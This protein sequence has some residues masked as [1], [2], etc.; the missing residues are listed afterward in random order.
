MSTLRKGSTGAE[1]KELQRLLN[2]AGAGLT[3]DGDFG[4]KTHNAVIKFQKDNGLEVDGIVGSNT[5]V[6][7][8]ALDY[9]AI[10]IINECV[11][12]IQSLPSFKKLMELMDQ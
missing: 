10:A 1:V 2:L 8:K 7:L 4:T 5:W 6:K 12:D 9:H 3:V 11:E